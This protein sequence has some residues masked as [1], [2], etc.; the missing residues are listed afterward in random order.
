M[1]FLVAAVLIGS[2]FA[3]PT[4]SSNVETSSGTLIGHP[5]SNKT[6][7]TEFLGIRYAE[8]PVGELR[9]A[10]PKKYVAPAGTVFQASDWVR[11]T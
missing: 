9:F 7:V 3:A 2:A 11:R 8:A 6:Q 10:A 1:Q 5:S 4:N